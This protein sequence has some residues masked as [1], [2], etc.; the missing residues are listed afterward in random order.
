[1]AEQKT[2]YWRQKQEEISRYSRRLSKR[3]NSQVIR[4][5]I[6]KSKYLSDRIFMLIVCAWVGIL[7]GIASMILKTAILWVEKVLS[8]SDTV[9][10]SYNYGLLFYPIIG[11]LITVFLGRR[12]FKTEFGQSFTDI[13]YAIAQ[14]KGKIPATNIFSRITCSV[15]TVGFGGSAGLESPVVMVGAAIG[16]NTG[17]RML[18]D[19]QKL[20]LLIG[21]GVAGV[22]AALF[23]APIGGVIFAIEV[24]LL[25]V[26]IGKGIVPLLLASISAKLTALVFRGGEA[27]Y[28]FRLKDDFMVS[29]VPFCILLGVISGLLAIYFS[30]VNKKIDALANQISNFYVR[31]I[32]GGLILSALI[33]IFPP[34]YGEGE[35]LLTSLLGGSE[36]ATFER[37]IIF[38]NL[39]PEWVFLLYILAMVAFKAVAT[40]IT[41][42]A[43]GCGGTFAP[44]LFMGGL[45][46]F[47]FARFINLYELGTLSEKNFTLMGMCGAISG[48]QYAPLTAIFLIA[49]ITQGYQLF[50]PLMLISAIAFVTVSAFDKHSPYTRA[51]IAKGDL[52]EGDTDR[53]AL[54]KMKINKLIE[55]NFLP[56]NINQ[57]LGDLT[58][59]VRK[60]QRNLYPVINDE[61]EFMGMIHLDDIRDMMFD[62]EQFE[63]VKVRSLMQEA[64]QTVEYGEDMES[65]MQK[66]EST[67]A[68]NLPVIKN[69]KYLGFISKSNIFNL[70]RRTV[71]DENQQAW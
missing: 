22:I 35:Y 50:V 13:L 39:P 21:A 57:N 64:P 14:K 7:S 58:Q 2:T 40:A 59:V 33:V 10:E 48:V 42:G 25:D 56:V 3:A 34:I 71:I 4:F 43:G 52:I 55:N 49:E 18:F 66:F 17:M 54:N 44:S 6:W 47:A 53:K 67:G 8:R 29:D 24:I 27:L 65:V 20:N 30:E 70:Y 26:N 36:V 62:F 46:G 61:Q 28:S 68:W 19:N 38:T 37:S 16:S 12:V 51:L 45:T 60:S 69:G 5:L 15:F 32:S 11:L 23:N 1:M 63:K 41:I 9:W 31:A